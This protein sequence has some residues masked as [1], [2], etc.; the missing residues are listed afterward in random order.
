MPPGSQMWRQWLAQHHNKEYNKLAVTMAIPD[1]WSHFDKMVE[2]DILVN[3]THVTMASS[4]DPLQ[5]SLGRHP[6]LSQRMYH[7]GK[8]VWYRSEERIDNF[9]YGGYLSR[10]DWRYNEEMTIILLHFAQVVI[11]QQS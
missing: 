8:E 7:K 3:R 6:G 4:V 2:Q 11:N 10:K 1:T 9:P 5:I